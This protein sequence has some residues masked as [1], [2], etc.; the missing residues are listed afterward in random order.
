[1][2]KSKFVELIGSSKALSSR[3]TNSI[4]GL[5]KTYPYCQTFRNILA[6]DKSQAGT[7]DAGTAVHS[8]AIHSS[9]RAQLQNFIEGKIDLQLETKEEI[10]ESPTLD[11]HFQVAKEEKKPVPAVEITPKAEKVDPV[12]EVLENKDAII[13]EAEK[14]VVEKEPLAELSIKKDAK[15]VEFDSGNKAKEDENDD[16]MRM[17]EEIKKRKKELALKEIKKTP[18]VEKKKKKPGRPKK[19][20]PTEELIKNIKQ[21]EKKPIRKSSVKAQSDI[22]KGYLKDEK[23]VAT[24]RRTAAKKKEDNQ[25]D[26]SVKSTSTAGKVNTETYAELLEKQGKDQEALEILNNIVA[27]YPEKKRKIAPKLKKLEEKIKKA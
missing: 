20:D 5:V 16:M 4:V 21:K 26:L 18:S 6:K 27:E 7:N 17:L 2:N 3:D 13:N 12:V 15:V 23:K 9:D 10:L 8:A 22:I 14:E 1:M 19:A 25:K 11:E 24:K